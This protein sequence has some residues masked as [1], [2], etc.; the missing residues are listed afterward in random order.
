METRRKIETMSYK[1][2]GSPAKLGT[3]QGTS[4]HKTALDNV[5]PVKKWDLEGM[6]G[7]ASGIGGGGGGSVWGALTGGV[8]TKSTGEFSD[9]LE[10]EDLDRN[11]WSGTI[12]GRKRDKER[13]RRLKELRAKKKLG[14]DRERIASSTGSMA[15]PASTAT[16]LEEDV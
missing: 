6:V 1:M 16:G 14:L 9:I 15:G 4:G 12:F 7:A 3:I 2:K 8:R 5:S 10:G 11:M 13:K